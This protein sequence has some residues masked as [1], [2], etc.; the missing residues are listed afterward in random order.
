MLTCIGE[1]C[2]LAVDGTRDR[3]CLCVARCNNQAPCVA[4]KFPG[5][6]GQ[7]LYAGSCQLVPG[8]PGTG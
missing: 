1:R 7:E 6:D 8:Y 2:R 4:V 5:K 3:V